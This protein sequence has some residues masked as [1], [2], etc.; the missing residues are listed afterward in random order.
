[1]N[2]D[3]N[4]IINNPDNKKSLDKNQTNINRCMVCN[5][6]LHLFKIKCK[7]EKYFCSEHRYSDKHD[8]TYNYKEENK[9][10]LTKLNPLIIAKKIENI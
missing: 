7:C 10:L 2:T 8:C 9:E 5:K 3:N 4:I 6:K 1:M